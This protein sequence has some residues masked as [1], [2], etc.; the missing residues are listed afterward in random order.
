MPW[1]ASLRSSGHPKSMS[2]NQ[3]DVFM[4]HVSHHYGCCGIDIQDL[5]TLLAHF[6]EVHA[7]AIDLAE[8]PTGSISGFSPQIVNDRERP[9]PEDAVEVE[10]DLDSLSSSSITVGPSAI[11][12]LLG[13]LT[14]NSSSLFTN[15][16]TDVYALACVAYE[17]LTSN[18]PFCEIHRD[19]TVTLKVK[20]GAKPPR[21][22][23][24]DRVGPWRLTPSA[25]LLMELC[26]SGEPGARPTIT[27]FVAGYAAEISADD[28]PLAVGNDSIITPAR[29]RDTVR[30]SG[31][32]SL[33]EIENMLSAAGSN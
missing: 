11:P 13:G 28:R 33:A 29:F 6:E 8:I 24:S 22:P 7:P 21:P 27:E 17:V 18:I 26:W 19:S 4:T 25:W 5:N 15:S 23:A 10:F 12:L 31:L 14:N 32:L 3:N 1:S 16:A 9:G 2:S 30:K 20:A